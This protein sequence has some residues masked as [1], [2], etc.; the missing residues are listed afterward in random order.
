MFI[1]THDKHQ[2]LY[3]IQSLQ[4]NMNEDQEWFEN[5]REENT[6]DPCP[7]CHKPLSLKII[8]R[9]EQT[10]F[11]LGWHHECWE[12][13]RDIIVYYAFQ[14]HPE[15]VNKLQRYNILNPIASET[16]S[17]IC[18]IHY[19]M[20][21]RETEAWGEILVN[22]CPHCGAY[23]GDFFVVHEEMLDKLDDPKSFC[24][25]D[26]YDIELTEAER[27]WRYGHTENNGRVSL[28][29]IRVHTSCKRKQ[30]RAGY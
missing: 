21:R 22:L 25:I 8:P 16:L 11:V 10:V 4:N 12:C 2:T 9:K 14:P 7:V 23:Q 3:I 18:E 1:G 20:V 28:K 17:E 30:S 15:D 27:A 5:D 29:P 24:S 26:K 19:K 6:E 13:H